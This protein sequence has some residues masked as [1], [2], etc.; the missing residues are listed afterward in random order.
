MNCLNFI[1]EKSYLEAVNAL[2]DEEVDLERINISNLVNR[3][4][5]DYNM[6]RSN[7]YSKYI[8]KATKLLKSKDD[9]LIKEEYKRLLK[10][11]FNYA[12]KVNDSIKE[13]SKFND[14]SNEFNIDEAISR[15][16]SIQLIKESYEKI[17]NEAERGY[18]DMLKDLINYVINFSGISLYKIYDVKLL[19]NEFLK[20]FDN[21]P[22]FAFGGVDTND[23]IDYRYSLKRYIYQIPFDIDFIEDNV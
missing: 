19:K 2:S 9:E 4:K 22:K 18:L 23:N 8:S 13:Y 12:V 7:L 1:D 11:S 17:Q 6:F 5:F 10:A 16:S 15:D 21:A 14:A 20:T 3:I